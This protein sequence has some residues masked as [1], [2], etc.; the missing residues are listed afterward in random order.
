MS[1]SMSNMSIARSTIQKYVQS[2]EWGKIVRKVKNK[3]LLT[4]KTSMID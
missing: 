3:P 4:Q 1:M 2:T